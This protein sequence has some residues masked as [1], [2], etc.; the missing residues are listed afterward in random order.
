M[1]SGQVGA[2]SGRGCEAAQR[3]F[4]EGRDSATAREQVAMARLV[5]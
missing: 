5:P 3:L 2:S 4:S 1:C